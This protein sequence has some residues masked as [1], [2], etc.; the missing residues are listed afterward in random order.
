MPRLE[1]E[2]GKV[3]W[4]KSDGAKSVYASLISILIGLAVGMI[5]IIIVGLAKDNISMKGIWDGIRLVFLGVFSTGRV[6]GQLTFGFNPIN[7]GNMLFRATPLILTGLSVAVAFKTGLFNIGAAGQY[8]MGT[9]GSISVAIW[10]GTSGCP[11]GL[12]WVCAF[13]TGIVLGALW[14]AI[15]GLFKAFLN[16]NEVITCIMTNWIAANL[17]TWWF[18]AHDVFKNAGEAG[19]IGYTIPLKNLGISTPKLGMDVLFP[20]SQANG[21]FWIACIIAVLMWVVMT[22]T[23]FGYE[24]RA[25]G[26]NRHAAKYAGINDKKNIIL[27]MVIAGALASA[28]GSLYFLSGN[29]EFYWSTYMSLPADG[30]NGIPVALLAVNH[31]IGVVFTG[32]F[33]SMLNVAGIQLKYMTAYNEYIADIII[34]TIVYL[35]AFALIFKMILNGRKKKKEA[36]EGGNK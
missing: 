5:V 16:I 31:P 35:S 25:C 14:G 22:K 30:F 23:T 11:V 15:P 9:M 13:L 3:K 26:L 8:L 19:K 34:A 20:G 32:I 29:T 17:V 33:M 21:G 10:M 24:L 18:D 28:A 2:S 4:Y 7:L 12:A 27:S 36:A 1:P 6:E